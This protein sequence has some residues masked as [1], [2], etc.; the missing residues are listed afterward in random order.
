M[1]EKQYREAVQSWADYAAQLV[2]EI[3]RALPNEYLGKIR[4][5]EAERM[6][7][8][9]EIGRKRSL[10]RRKEFSSIYH[11]IANARGHAPDVLFHFARYLEGAGEK[12]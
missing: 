6:R 3:Q 11:V 8:T 12:R 1:R 2:G 5:M 7:L 4:A 10:G 9:A